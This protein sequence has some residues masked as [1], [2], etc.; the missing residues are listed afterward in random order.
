MP[1][2]KI[3]QFPLGLRENL[4]YH[5]TKVEV[6]SAE[7]LTA[8]SAPIT[9]VAA[10]GAGKMLIPIIVS[11]FYDYATAVYATNT[12]LD[13]YHSTGV[14]KL[15]QIAGVIDQ[16]ADRYGISHSANV[17]ISNITPNEALILKGPVGDPTGGGG[18]LTIYLWYINLEL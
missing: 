1:D 14:I 13:V 2:P 3:I 12:E 6:S 7:I 11:Y 5:Y 8:N 16:A 18:T 10:P 4:Q 15:N 17:H 9:L